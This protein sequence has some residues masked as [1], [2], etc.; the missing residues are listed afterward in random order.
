MTLVVKVEMDDPTSL[1][2]A[3]RKAVSE[4]DP[5][6][7]LAGLTDMQ[8]VVGQA[9]STISFVSLLL[10]IAAGV[11]MLLSAVGLYGVISYVVTRRTREIGMRMAIGARPATVQR[12]VVGGS[13]V[14]VVAGIVLGV[15][16]ALVGARLMQGLLVG[17]APSD[18][19]AYAVASGVLAVVAL[20][21]SWIPAW[22]AS[23]LDPVEALRVE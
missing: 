11:A 10:A 2:P 21:A 6:V 13:L 15:G 4:V 1:F 8:A 20:V 17:V 16:L 14:L 19:T 3:I 7:P 22:R 18:P 12:M 5:E 9:T 23:R